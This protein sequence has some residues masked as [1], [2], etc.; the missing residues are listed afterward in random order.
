MTAGGGDITRELLAW[1]GGDRAA[2]DK[3]LQ[4]V[5][6]EL[7]RLARAQLRG[8]RAGHTLQTADLVN[9]AY[10]RLIDQKRTSFQNRTH[11]F[12]IAARV[13][14]R[15][16]L[17]H[18]RKKATARRGAGAPSDPLQ[19]ASSVAAPAGGLELVESLALHDALAT[20]EKLS[21]R[22]GRV[23]ELRVFGG[24]TIR[25]A[26]E[27]MELSPATIKREFEVARAWLH[28]ELTRR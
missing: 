15:I 1:S 2:L 22:Q 27:V 11:F 21:P 17:D 18:A 16:L 13:M 12:A 26:A 10:L 14:R 3:L 8:E 7:K 20:L 4:R 5:E 9:E 6:G 25:E 23:V 19:E 28:R 24:L